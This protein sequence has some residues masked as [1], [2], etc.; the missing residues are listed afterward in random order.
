MLKLKITFPDD[1]RAILEDPVFRQDKV[2][3]NRLLKEFMAP[4]F[5][6]NRPNT[7][8]TFSK[9]SLKD[10]YDFGK[11][12]FEV[13]PKLGI[14]SWHIKGTYTTSNRGVTR[15]TRLYNVP[16]KAISVFNRWGLHNVKQC[17]FQKTF[18]NSVVS[19]C[20]LTHHNLYLRM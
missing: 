12:T 16:S 6:I 8:E 1:P 4:T 11:S 20:L 17:L 15:A 10:I 2:L 18:A 9:E 13:Q 5:I 19:H 14:G 7:G 3:L